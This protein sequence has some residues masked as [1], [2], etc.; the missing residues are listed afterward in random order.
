[1]LCIFF[2]GHRSKDCCRRLRCDI[3]QKSHPTLLH[4][5]VNTEVAYQKSQSNQVVSNVSSCTVEKGKMSCSVVPVLLTHASVPDRSKLVYALLDSQSDASFV[6][7]KTLES[8]NVSSVDV[9]S[10]VSTLTRVSQ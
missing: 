4:I 8:F 9:N 3:C 2:S 1:M 6:L 10:S 5:P 7:D